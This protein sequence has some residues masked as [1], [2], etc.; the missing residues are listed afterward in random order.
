MQNPIKR[1]L[2]ERHLSAQQAAIVT[3]MNAGTFRAYMNGGPASI[4]WR[5][6]NK[7]AKLGFDPGAIMMEY[8]AWREAEARKLKESMRV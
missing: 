3:G 7:F 6:A 2:S 4:G 1:C 5:T 8:A